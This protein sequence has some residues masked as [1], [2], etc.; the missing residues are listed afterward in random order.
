MWQKVYL[1]LI[2]KIGFFAGNGFMAEVLVVPHR[3]QPPQVQQK[4]CKIHARQGEQREKR[5]V[6]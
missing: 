2:F 3:N 4:K 1:E 6:V 5:R